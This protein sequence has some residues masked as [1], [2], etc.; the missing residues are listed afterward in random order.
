MSNKDIF[1]H[2]SQLG[3][4]YIFDVLLS[5][6][7]P[8]VFV[9]QDIYD[10]KYLFYEMDSTDDKDVWLVSKVTKKEYYSLVDGKKSIQRVYENKKDFDIFSISKTYGDEDVIELTFDGKQWLSHL[11]Q[12]PVY[13]EKKPVED[14]SDE[15]LSVARKTGNTIFDIRLFPG[16]DR[17]YVPQNILTDL[18]NAV[19]TLT[20][21]VLGSKRREALRVAT[22]PGSCI[23]RFSF[24]DQINLLDESNCINEMNILNNVLSAESLS[25]SLKQ[26][27]NQKSFVRSCSSL[28]DAI[29]KTN[30]DVQ[31]VTASPN[32]NDVR[33]IVLTNENVKTRFE[34]VKDMYSVLTKQVRL[35]GKLIGLDMKTKRFKFQTVDGSV[36]IGTVD[37]NILENG[38]FEIPKVYDANMRVEVYLDKNGDKNKEKYF[39]V[40]LE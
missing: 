10:C 14:M 4:L 36:K 1:M 40:S 12:N 26:V 5:Y 27:K 8:R 23:I 25:E 35:N 15:T 24:P 29:R 19:T 16:T 30:S 28:L 34:Y 37:S 6:I 33:Q 7:Y 39:L 31:F 13:A 38:S 2:V 17:H 32:S 20:G 18:C 3:D 11:P 21:S 9:C 22:A